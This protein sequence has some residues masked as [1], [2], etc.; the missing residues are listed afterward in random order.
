MN[1]LLIPISNLVL[2]QVIKID[3]VIIF[4][5]YYENIN[6]I[7]FDLDI[8]DEEIRTLKNLINLNKVLI[9]SCGDLG[10]N[11]AMLKI[12]DDINC[13]NNID[14][15]L[16]KNIYH[17][18]RLLDYIRIQYC[19]FNNK[20]TLIGIPGLMNN[21]RQAF[22]FDNSLNLISTIKGKHI[23]YFMQPGIGLDISTYPGWKDNKI[24]SA[25]I[26][27][28][29]DEV[30]LEFRTILSRAC[31]SMHIIDINRCFCYLF[32]TVERMGSQKYCKFE[33]RKKRIISFISDS[34]EEF[35]LLSNQFYFYSKSVR[36]EIIHKGKN[37]LD[38]IPIAKTNE[39]INNLFLLIVRF[40]LKVINSN[41]YTFNDLDNYLKEDVKHFEY[42]TPKLPKTNF[43]SEIILGDNEFTFIAPINNLSFNKI[44]KL[45]NTLFIPKNS[46]KTYCDKLPWVYSQFVLGESLQNI[47]ELETPDHKII[48]L[49][50][51][52]DLEEDYILALQ[53]ALS[54]KE[55]FELNQKS[56]IAI[57]FNQPYLNDSDY[58]PVK[59]SEFCDYLCNN[60]NKEL[61]YLILSNCDIRIKELLPS[62]AGLLNNF[63][64]LY[65]F[66]YIYRSTDSILGKVYNQYI[67]S[68]KLFIIPDN[69]EITD[70][71]LYKCLYN[72]RKDEISFLCSTALTRLCECYYINDYTIMVS[73][74]FDILDM[75]DPEDTEGSK[76]KSRIFPFVFNTKNEYSEACTHFKKIRNSYR[77]PLIHHGKSIYD[78]ISTEEEIYTLFDYIKNIIISFCKAVFSSNAKTFDELEIEREKRKR[79]LNL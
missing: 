4:P 74:L 38:I 29:D 31:Y 68:D 59:S 61:N 9:D 76:L 8:K 1:Y 7:H 52:K 51:F 47:E 57:I 22:Y 64:I 77:N 79:F 48:N 43:T 42:K 18:N 55:I 63:R 20:E 14:S 10:I 5:C 39:I 26:N 49:A 19:N 33:E 3:E 17:V 58:S 15:F 28:R 44:L 41:I 21:Y 72:N 37:I 32:S 45:G 40:S 65:Y 71:V 36:T 73:Y 23:L 78:L 35:N 62:Q 69:F 66:D 11:L 56:S 16:E 12:Q 27:N 60:I 50:E 13:I 6:T 34:Q 54:C 70:K 75:L 24:Y 53:S 67:E 30:Y 46:A 25:L 2:D